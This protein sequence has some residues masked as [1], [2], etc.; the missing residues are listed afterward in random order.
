MRIATIDVGTN[1]CHLLIVELSPEGGYK[2]LVKERE[3]VM[4][5]E[6]G[7]EQQHITDAAAAR[8]IE[9]LQH[10][11][12][13][14]R[15]HHVDAIHAAA[16]SAVRSAENGNAFTRAV[17]EQ[18]GIHVHVISGLEEARLIYLGTR[19]DLDYSRGRVLQFDTGGGSTEFVLSDVNN[20]LY[21]TSLPLGHIR[22]TDAFHTEPLLDTTR[23]ELEAHIDQQLDKLIARVGPQDFQTL[24]ATAG[25]AR[26]LASLV[27]RTQGV[28]VPHTHGLTLKREELR[29][30][31][32]ILC[33]T[34]VDRPLPGLAKLETRRRGTVGAGGVLVLRIMDRMEKPELQTSERSLRDGLRED[35][36]EKHRPEVRL[37]RTVSDPRM[38]S[39]LLAMQ[40][41]HVDEGHAEHVANLCES[42]FDLLS[43]EHLLRIDDRR[44]LRYGAMLHDIGHH[45]SGK[46]HHKH[47][48]YLLENIRMVG[49]PASE[50]KE[51]GCL[52]R[53]HRGSR[54]KKSHSAFASLDRE[55]K[56]RVRQLS[57]MLRFC[58]AL[59]RTHR[60][61][62]RRLTREGSTLIAWTE[63]E[64]VVEGF[65]AMRRLDFLESAFGTRFSLVVRE[66][67]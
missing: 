57:A 28:E 46:D 34:P 19:D 25:T 58:D 48:Q 7:F 5:G 60:G 56:A 59:D 18:T 16:T 63:S 67:Q 42:M 30:V 14:S 23:A 17:R 49:F 4:L 65:A 50:V 13:V 47:G 43:D 22:M 3:Q 66:A 24:L 54:P 45:I 31:V 15:A 53:Y 32:D 21:G 64:A 41:Y 26:T 1:S 27:L 52:V 62:I 36:I 10:F 8:G 51:L 38:R 2:V 20:M 35:W 37:A 39:V 61:V 55:G 29:P 6:G 12:D 33:K 11:A 9:T 40:R 44:M